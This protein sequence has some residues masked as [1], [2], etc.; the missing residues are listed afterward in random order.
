[1]PHDSSI[2]PGIGRRLDDRKNIQNESAGFNRAR[3]LFWP[4]VFGIT[5]FFGFFDGLKGAFVG[6]LY[7]VAAGLFLLHENCREEKK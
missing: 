2:R 5:I 7:G 6:F 3:F 1:M 4:I